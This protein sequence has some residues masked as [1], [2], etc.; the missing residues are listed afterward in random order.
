MATYGPGMDHSQHFEISQS[1]NKSNN[2]VFAKQVNS[3]LRK[4]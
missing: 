1:Y 4:L 2:L 3:A